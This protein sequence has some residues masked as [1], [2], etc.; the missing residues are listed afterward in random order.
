MDRPRRGHGRRRERRDHVRAPL[1][2]RARRGLRIPGLRGAAG[3]VVRPTPAV[4]ADSRLRADAS[5]RE[6]VQWVSAVRAVHRAG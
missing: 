4:R 6:H 1:P 5:R 3:R 2:S